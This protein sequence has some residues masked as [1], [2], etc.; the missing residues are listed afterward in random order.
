LT[1]H[2]GYYGLLRNKDRIQFLMHKLGL[3]EH[4]DKKVRMLS[5]GMKRRLL[6]AKALVHSPKLLLLDEPTAGVDIELRESLWKFV[7]ELQKEGITILL[8]T[9]YL[10]EAEQ[11]CHRV[12]I[13]DRGVLLKLGETSKLIKDFT[14]REV[15]FVLNK[16]MPIQHPLLK[17]VDGKRFTFMM[18]YSTNLGQL[19]AD[20]GLELNDV[21]DVTIRE[22]SLEDA[23]RSLLGGHRG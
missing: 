16:E 22:G 10:E 20:C 12:G 17:H 11:L 14:Q 15:C 9:H 3:Y 13:I 4:K 1:F 8:T 21:S 19:F 2:S 23:F 6:V 7:Q 5:G 18:P